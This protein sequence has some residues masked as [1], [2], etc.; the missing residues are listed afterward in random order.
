MEGFNSECWLQRHSSFLSFPFQLNFPLIQPI[1]RQLSHPCSMEEAEEV[2]SHKS[3]KKSTVELRYMGTSR[4]IFNGQIC[5]LFS[6]TPTFWI[7]EWKLCSSRKLLTFN[8]TTSEFYCNEKGGV[9]WGKSPWISYFPPSPPPPPSFL[10]D[11]CRLIR[12]SIPKSEHRKMSIICEIYSAFQ[13][14]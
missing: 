4:F 5:N 9:G 6:W 14:C 10:L 2:Q 1:I 7:P 13:Y 8:F 11:R 3:W 12:P